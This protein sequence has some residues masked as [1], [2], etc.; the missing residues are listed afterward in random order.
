MGLAGV[1]IGAHIRCQTGGRLWCEKPRVGE[2]VMIEKKS[3]G[4]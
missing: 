3:I 1:W 4:E 2:G